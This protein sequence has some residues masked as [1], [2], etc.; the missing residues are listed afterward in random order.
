MYGLF[1][2][3]AGYGLYTIDDNAPTRFGQY[4][5]NQP[6]PGI[7]KP[8]FTVDNLDPTKEHTL[9]VYYDN[10]YYGDSKKYQLALSLD[11]FTYTRNTTNESSSTA[12]T[13]SS[14]PSSSSM[15]SSSPVPHTS[16]VGAIVGGVIGGFIVLFAALALMLVCMRRG[17]SRRE[18]VA[19]FVIDKES[20]RP[21]ST[22]DLLVTPWTDRTGASSSAP[23]QSLMK[24]SLADGISTS[25]SMSSKNPQMSES[26]YSA[27][28]GV[29]NDNSRAEQEQDPG[30]HKFN[31][32]SSFI[33]P[34]SYSQ[35]PNTDSSHVS[36]AVD[37][38]D[39]SSSIPQYASGPQNAPPIP[40]AFIPPRTEKEKQAQLF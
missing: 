21:L 9:F 31:S 24:R 29:I 30:L 22:G 14:I 38:E 35:P 4:D 36:Q 12:S 40:P 15:A 37:M 17:R 33:P 1:S 26:S 8:S 2:A 6:W 32:P 19:A 3:I 5:E 7:S 18:A 13:S 11:Y 27:S 10:S 34:H 39:V 16:P 25:Q 23:S 28:S 20:P